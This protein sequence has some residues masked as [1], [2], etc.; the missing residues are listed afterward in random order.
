LGT[1]PLRVHLAFPSNGA[2]GRGHGE[3]CCVI[4]IKSPSGKSNFKCDVATCHWCSPDC[5]LGEGY[6]VPGILHVHAGC[7]SREYASSCCNNS[8]AWSRWFHL[9]RV[10]AAW[11]EL[12]P[13]LAAVRVGHLELD[14]VVWGWGAMVSKRAGWNGAATVEDRQAGG[15]PEGNDHKQRSRGRRECGCHFANSRSCRTVRKGRD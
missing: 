3:A 15:Q 6:S 9:D 5:R 14:C 13:D 12:H 4:T 10:L 1:G 7:R 2:R 11:L 8:T